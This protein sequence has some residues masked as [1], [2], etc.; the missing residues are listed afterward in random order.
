MSKRWIT[1]VHIVIIGSKSL[2][3]KYSMGQKNSLR[4]FGYNSA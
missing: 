1:V 2:S 3:W 4:A